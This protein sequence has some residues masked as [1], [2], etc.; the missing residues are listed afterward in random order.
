M[1]K[2]ANLIFNTF[3]SYNLTS[4]V[5]GKSALGEH[6]SHHASNVFKYCLGNDLQDFCT[7]SERSSALHVLN[8]KYLAY[9]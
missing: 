9:C 4:I 7:N 6:S 5:L 8:T 1:K 3:Y 2:K